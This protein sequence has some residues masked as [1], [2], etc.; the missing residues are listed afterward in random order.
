M[1]G[2]FPWTDELVA[3]AA[4]RYR[5]GDSNTTIAQLLPTRNAVAGKL[6]RMGLV[7]DVRQ[8][9]SSPERLAPRRAAKPG[10]ISP[11]VPSRTPD[12]NSSA[13]QRARRI[14]I[15]NELAKATPMPTRVAAAKP[16]RLIDLDVG[17]YK[18]P[19]D[20]NAREPRLMLFCA[21]PTDD[22]YCARHAKIC[23]P[24]WSKKAA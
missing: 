9:P 17:Q 11:A 2:V 14:A 22:I 4:E 12:P 13:G 6:H 10:A 20:D 16:R 19:L 24:N 21:E 1:R 8:K 5:L 18:Y 7:R 15:R 23:W 3:F